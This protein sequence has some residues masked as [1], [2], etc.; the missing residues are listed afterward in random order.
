[1]SLKPGR[2]SAPT[3]G[4]F[5]AYEV[6]GAGPPLATTHPYAM[7]PHAFAP[8]PGVTTITVWPR[9]FGSSSA[10]RDDNDYGLSR[11]AD[12]LEAVRTHLGLDRWSIWGTSMGG[13]TA[14]TYA[15]RYPD[16]LVALVLDSTAASYRYADDPESIWPA[17]RTSPEALA[18]GT[19]P[20][21]ETREAFFAKNRELERLKDPHAGEATA[22]FVFNPI[23][24]SLIVRSLATYDL[25]SRLSSIRVPT[26]V[27]SGELDGQCAP[28]QSREIAA[29]IPGARLETYAGVG[30]GVVL[31]GPPGVAALAGGF[32]VRAAGG[33]R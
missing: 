28:G 4:G 14:L 21:A 13:F 8:L 10:P 33:S 20:T 18:F 32:V 16:R 7:P 29:G 15:V 30:H 9:G 23:A 25:S 1:M 24:L 2:G 31:S 6:A 12:D 19:N 11:L 26:L 17:A 27:L 5:I 3:D 22:D